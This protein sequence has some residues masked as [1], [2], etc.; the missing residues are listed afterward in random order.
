MPYKNILL[1]R[2]ANTGIIKINR[3]SVRNALNHE[4]IEEMRHAF[5]KLEK[6]ER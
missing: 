5:E 2:L 3:P 4:T 1:E 6:D